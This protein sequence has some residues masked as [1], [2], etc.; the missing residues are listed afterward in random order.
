[1]TDTKVCANCEEELPTKFFSI[2]KASSDGLQRK[3]RAC[4][5]HYQAQRRAKEGYAQQQTKYYQQRHEELKDDLQY[6]LRKLL[7]ASRA[8]AKKK[9]LYHDLQFE[10]VLEIFPMDMICPVFGCEMEWGVGSNSPLS[11]SIDRIDSSQ[12]YT[13]DN[14]QIMCWRANRIKADASL[15][16]LKL[17]VDYLGG[18]S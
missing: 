2:N 18:V 12:G 4:D 17:L 9:N 5:R 3:C 1:M 13:I 15:N 7:N 6:R 11:P 8:R 14:V 10:E 16:E